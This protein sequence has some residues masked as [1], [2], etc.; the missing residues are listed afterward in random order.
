MRER[1]ASGRFPAWLKK[2][3]PSGPGGARVRGI[4]EGLRLNTVCRSA[5]CPNIGECFHKGA[6][7]FLIMGPVCTRRCRF[8]AVGGGAVE[9]LSPDEPE[10]VA[11]AARELA[12]RHVVVT[13]VTRDD[14]ADG[15][16]GHFARVVEALRR[17]TEATVEVLVPDFAGDERS[18]RRVVES[19]PDVF[20]HNVETVERLYAKVRPGADY[21]RSLAVL[22]AA[23]SMDESL[24]TKSGMMVGLG[25]SMDEVD[26]VLGD[27]VA[28]RTSVVT[29]GQYLAPSARHLAVERFVE[30]EEFAALE[31]RAMEMGFAAASCGPL[32]RSSY[33]AE[34]VFRR[35]KARR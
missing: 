6:A 15:G 13:S 2:R 12:L 28:A 14:I 25:E 24:V 23:A 3:L 19:G 9:P 5:L 16:A 30:P 26:A 4:L 27:L 7:T 8:C 21:G 35:T 10:R 34:E 32:V 29:V 22:A 11:Q 1:A 33:C 31:R 17:R 18:V 20:N